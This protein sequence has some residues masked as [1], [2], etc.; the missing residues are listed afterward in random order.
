MFDGWTV[1]PRCA[2]QITHSGHLVECSAC[3]FFLYAHSAV[4]ANALPEDDD[5]RL[6]LA[7]RAIEPWRGRWDILG[8]FLGEGEHP[9]DGVRR[10]LLEE[11]TLEFEPDRYLGGWMGDYDGRATLNLFWTGRFGP[12]EP[13][14]HDDVAELRWFSRDELPM[15]EQLA[16]HRL[17]PDV[18]A[19]WRNEHA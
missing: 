17:V 15:P 16:F 2:N 13:R 10:E 11:T 5:G 4:T 3:G 9:L 1:C 12:G 18:L 7:R 6:L 14:A 8:G 19:A